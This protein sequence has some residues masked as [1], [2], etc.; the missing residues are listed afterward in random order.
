MLQTILVPLD[1]SAF[2]ERALP[3]AEALALWAEARLLLMR[4]VHLRSLPGWH[5]DAA[6]R[7]AVEAAAQYLDQVAEGLRTSGLEVE[8]A[9]LHGEAAAAILD[10]VRIAAADLVVMS[11]HG[12]GGLGRWLHGGVADQLLRQATVPVLLVPPTCDRG[13]DQG[14]P[15]R[16]LVPLDGSSFAEEALEPIGDLARTLEVEV[17]LLEIVEPSSVVGADG[18]VYAAFDPDGDLRT[19]N[20]YLA[21]VCEL[22]RARGAA[23]EASAF[24]GHPVAAIVEHAGDDGADLIALATHGHGDLAQML[25]GNICSGRL[26]QGCVPLLLVRPDSIHRPPTASG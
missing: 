2:A 17:R 23:V 5:R 19:A 14:R 4:A 16:L 25:I 21:E 13:W 10:E 26:E 8:T 6:D 11:T 12:H 22:L 15:L 9:V 20:S 18:F 3:Y 7:R 24:F 1:G